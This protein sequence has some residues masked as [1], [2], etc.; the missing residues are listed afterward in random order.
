MSRFDREAG[1]KTVIAPKRKAGGQVSPPA[2]G[3][4]QGPPKQLVKPRQSSLPMGVFGLTA[5]LLTGAAASRSCKGWGV[6]LS[7]NP[8][9]QEVDAMTPAHKRVNELTEQVIAMRLAG[10]RPCR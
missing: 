2:A 7:C 3:L 8:R 5:L 9:R 6:C 1:E 4:A 10:P